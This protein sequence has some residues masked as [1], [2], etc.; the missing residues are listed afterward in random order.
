LEVSPYVGGVKKRVKA[1]K[2]KTGEKSISYT[3]KQ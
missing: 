3:I 1:K 2:K